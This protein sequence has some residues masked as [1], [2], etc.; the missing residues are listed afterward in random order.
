LRRRR[1]H[2]PPSFGEWVVRQFSAGERLRDM[3]FARLERTCTNAA[4]IVC[5]A[6]WSDPGAAHLAVPPGGE[7]L[8]D[9]RLVASRSADGFQACLA[10]RQHTVITWPWEHLGTRVAWLMTQAGTV[11]ET[12]AGRLLLAIASSYAE[13]AREQLGTALGLWE[14]V[15]AGLPAGQAASVRPDLA[16]MARQFVAAFEQELVAAGTR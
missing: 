1:A 11:A 12:E 15:A 4:S 2:A 5:A 13:I 10:D 16:G 14:Q 3:T 8:A 7:G 6:A 9:A